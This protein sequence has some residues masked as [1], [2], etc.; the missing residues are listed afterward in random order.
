MYAQYA[1]LG[2]RR[3]RGGETA[4]LGDAGDGGRSGGG[5]AVGAQRQRR[6]PPQHHAPAARQVLGQQVPICYDALVS[7]FSTI[8][9]PRFSTILERRFSTIL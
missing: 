2:L 9:L 6:A 4:A 7:Q 1:A 8:L 5:G 3:E